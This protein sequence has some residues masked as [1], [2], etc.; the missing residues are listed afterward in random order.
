VSV[1]NILLGNVSEC[2]FNRLNL[3]STSEA[4]LAFPHGNSKCEE[5]IFNVV[6]REVLT[7]LVEWE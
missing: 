7:P 5:H 4:I 3:D 1:Q 2:D 6:G